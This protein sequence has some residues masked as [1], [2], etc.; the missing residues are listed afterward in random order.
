MEHVDCYPKK[1]F[2]LMQVPGLTRIQIA[3]HLQVHLFF[4]NKL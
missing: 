3:S 1:I 2:E 4:K